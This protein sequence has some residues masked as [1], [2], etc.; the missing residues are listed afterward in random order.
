VGTIPTRAPKDL[1]A[2]LQDY[3]DKEQLNRS[4][5]VRKLLSEGLEA[6]RREQALDRVV[7][8]EPSPSSAAD[9]AVLARAEAREAVAVM[10][11]AAGRSAAEVEGI[12]TRGTARLVL[13]AVKSGQLPPNA[14]RKTIDTMIESGWYVAPDLYTRIVQKLETLE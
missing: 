9:I 1:E 3:L 11:E 7:D 4:T 8:G 6:W 13:S 5:G 10:D 14:A 12:D 2:E